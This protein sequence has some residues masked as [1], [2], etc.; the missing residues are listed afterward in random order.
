MGQYSWTVPSGG[1]GI[2]PVSVS[3]SSGGSPSQQFTFYYTDTGGASSLGW[4]EAAFGQDQ[5]SCLVKS[6]AQTGEIRLYNP[7]GV[8]YISGGLGVAGTMSNVNCTVDPATS[9]QYA[10][11]TQAW[12]APNMTFWSPL[13][14]TQN[15]FGNAANISGATGNWATLGTWTVPNNGMYTKGDASISSSLLPGTSTTTDNMTGQ[16]IPMYD[17]YTPGPSIHL[18]GP[19][20][21]YFP[22][23]M[24]WHDVFQVQLAHGTP[25]TQVWLL[26]H[27]D[28]INAANQD[29]SNYQGVGTNGLVGTTDANGNFVYTGSV[30]QVTGDHSLI[31]YEGNAPFNTILIPNTDD[32]LMSDAARQAHFGSVTFWAQCPSTDPAVCGPDDAHNVRPIYSLARKRTKAQVAE[33]IEN[34]RSHIRAWIKDGH[35]FLAPLVVDG[36]DMR[37]ELAKLKPANSLEADFLAAISSI[38][39]VSGIDDEKEVG[40]TVKQ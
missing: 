26:Y 33:S 29:V 14:G 27:T 3:P 16:T 28:Y 40:T 4:L 37:A 24:T 18:T 19:N 34:L 6:N 8:N 1:S 15:L 17:S 25:N 23:V 2:T 22:D 30:V 21:E 13:A 5:T 20:G 36:A 12:F 39:D 11:G 9:W 10:T 31:F 35:T 32:G 7:D 38:L